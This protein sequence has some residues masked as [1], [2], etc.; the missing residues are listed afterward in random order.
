MQLP[1]ISPELLK[2]Y[3]EEIAKK[4]SPATLKE[5]LLLF[6]SFLVG[7]TIKAT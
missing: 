3:Q 5:K 1:K 4:S 7:L 2:T 6:L